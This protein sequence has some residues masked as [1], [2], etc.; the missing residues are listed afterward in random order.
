M[1]DT[2]KFG[3]TEVPPG[4]VPME[5][6]PVFVLSVK[7]TVGATDSVT[8]ELP[9]CVVCSTWS[10]AQVKLPLAVAEPSELL[11]T[12][13]VGWTLWWF[14]SVYWTR[15]AGGAAGAAVAAAGGPAGAPGSDVG[16]PAGGGA[17]TGGAGACASATAV[18]RR[19]ARHTNRH[20]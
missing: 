18:E 1:V 11:L 16:A 10:C 4:L 7:L 17:G 9:V 20:R 2:P 12:A 14:Q 13:I 19:R 3:V 6:N 5:N 8:T 15:G